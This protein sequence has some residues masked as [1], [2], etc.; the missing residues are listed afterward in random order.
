[1]R[2]TFLFQALSATLLSLTSTVHAND[3][4]H[5]PYVPRDIRCPSNSHV[6]FLHNSYTY[7]AP[8]Y[9]FTNITGSFFDSSWYVRGIPTITTTGIDNVPGATRA[10]V[11]GNSTF[12][13]TL[14]MYSM[15]PD[16]LIYSYHGQ[17]ITYVLPNVPPAHFY[18]YAE[19]MRFESICGGKATYIDLLSYMCSND[20]V[21]AYNLWY[22]DHM[23][24]FEGMAANLGA[25]V[26]AGDCPCSNKDFR[27][28]GKTRTTSSL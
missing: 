17:P 22:L 27:G 4:S 16:A 12:N 18:G 13:E 3:L 14:T 1:M 25:T 20:Q 10:G 15:Y 26:L 2:S 8:L 6:G 21:A 19:T 28:R 11:V 24:T 5:Y 9:K 23:S 7:N